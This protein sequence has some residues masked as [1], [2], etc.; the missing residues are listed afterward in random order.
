[1]VLDTIVVN[2]IE[3][4]QSGVGRDHMSISQEPP[5]LSQSHC[6]RFF[7]FMSFNLSRIYPIPIFELRV[8]AQ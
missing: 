6:K 1:M 7:A 2:S 3:L 8:V 5:N 4:S